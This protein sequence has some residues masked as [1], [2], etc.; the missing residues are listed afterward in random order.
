MAQLLL[1]RDFERRLI[2]MKILGEK[3]IIQNTLITIY[4][5]IVL[6]LSATAKAEMNI[7]PVFTD[8]QAVQTETFVGQVAMTVDQNFY[9]IVSDTEFYQLESNVD[10]IGYNGQQVAIE[11]YKIMHSIGPATH[12]SSV[13]PLPGRGDQAVAAPV[14]VVFGI[15]EVAN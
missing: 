13:D 5:L 4:I 10:L 6:G 7:N 12:A 11:A 1:N 2:M 9:L 15:S 14:L 3:N 8:H